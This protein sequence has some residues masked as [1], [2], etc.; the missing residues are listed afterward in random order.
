MIVE[1]TMRN[2]HFYNGN[3]WQISVVT[4][5]WCICNNFVT[6][7][8]NY[9]WY[10]ITDTNPSK[11]NIFNGNCN[12]NCHN[13]CDGFNFVINSITNR[14]VKWAPNIGEGFVTDFSLQ[15]LWQFVFCHKI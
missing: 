7:L 6:E 1:N 2:K 4:N 5:L 14:L 11:N 8:K 9:D 15:N 10:F 3:L 13:I 12:E